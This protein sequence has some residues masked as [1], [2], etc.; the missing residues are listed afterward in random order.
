[1]KNLAVLFLFVLLAACAAPQ[2]LPV[3]TGIPAPAITE[4]PEPID[5]L[6][7]EPTS[8]EMVASEPTV[9]ATPARVLKHPEFSAEYQP[10]VAESYVGVVSAIEVPINIGMSHLVVNRD[11]NP[12]KGIDLA[13]DTLYVWADLYLRSCHNRFVTVMGNEGVS[14]EDYLELVKKGE[15]GVEMVVFDEDGG[16]SDLVYKKLIDPRDGFSLT[17]SDQGLLP[18]KIN[19][20]FYAYYGVNKDGQLVMAVDLSSK[21]ISEYDSSVASIY[22]DQEMLDTS[23]FFSRIQSMMIGV[24]ILEHRCLQSKDVQETCGL[25]KVPSNWMEILETYIQEEELLY[26]GERTKFVHFDRGKE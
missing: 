5:A 2:A 12:I 16:R 23:M 6:V 19:D 1:M 18:I 9:E 20:G 8:D 17:F 24:A 25:V 11:E 10:A 15:G 4:S 3:A 21:Y 22:D 13:E 26:K 14:Y 7:L